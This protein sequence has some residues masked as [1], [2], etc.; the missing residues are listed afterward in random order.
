MMRCIVILAVVTV[1]LLVTWEYVSDVLSYLG[2][3]D[4]IC[5]IVSV[6]LK[7]RS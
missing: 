1:P 3:A 6:F 4:N 7:V 5:S 2:V